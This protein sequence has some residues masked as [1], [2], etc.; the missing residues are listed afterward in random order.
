MLEELS[1][2]ILGANPGFVSCAEITSESACI[3]SLSAA[4]SSLGQ[5]FF[6]VRSL[7]H[8]SHLFYNK[9][10][11]Q[12]AYDKMTGLKAA[13]MTGNRCA[14]CVVSIDLGGCESAEEE[15]MNYTSSSSSR[16]DASELP[17]FLARLKRLLEARGT[18]CNATVPCRVSAV[19]APGEAANQTKSSNTKAH[20]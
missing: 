10:S 4:A 13:L 16:A 6:H 2:L 7:A 15:M 11:D 3:A 18:L 14:P 1:N 20:N 17:A 9:L 12:L 5:R 19:P 8:Y